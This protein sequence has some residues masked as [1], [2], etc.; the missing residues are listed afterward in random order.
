MQ[1]RWR[2]LSPE[3]RRIF[4]SNAER[5]MRMTP[6]EQKVMREREK[7]HRAKLKSEA[8]TILRQSGLHLDQEKQARFEQRYIQERSKMERQLHQEIEAKRKQELPALNQRLEKEF[9]KSSPAATSHSSTPAPSASGSPR[10]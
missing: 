10:K 3:E 4:R 9:Q 7:E 5:W 6:E 1:Q 8:D 2:S